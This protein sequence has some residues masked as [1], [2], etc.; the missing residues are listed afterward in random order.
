MVG[1]QGKRHVLQ[2]VA[3]VKDDAHKRHLV[4]EGAA[5]ALRADD[6]G[7]AAER[8]VMREIDAAL[9]EPDS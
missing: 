9:E 4:R 8:A 1:V 7:R 2:E 6:Q 3:V 5:I